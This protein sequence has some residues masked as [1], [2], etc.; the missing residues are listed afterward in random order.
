M[1]RLA[2]MNFGQNTAAHLCGGRFQLFQFFLCHS[3]LRL[4]DY[5]L[6][7]FISSAVKYCGS[8]ESN[9]IYSPVLG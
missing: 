2:G 9:S 7:I 1:T 6:L 5:S 4:H 3:Y 8:A